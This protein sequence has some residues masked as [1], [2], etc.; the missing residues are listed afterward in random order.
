MLFACLYL[1]VN[2]LCLAVL[3]HRRYHTIWPLFL[4]FQTLTCVQ[5]GIRLYMIAHGLDTRE[6]WIRY[7]V[8]PET[9]L[10]LASVG[11]TLESLWKSLREIPIWRPVIM[12]GLCCW[13]TF[14]TSLFLTLWPAGDWYDKFQVYRADVFLNLA[15]LTFIGFWAGLHYTQ[16]WPRVARMHAGLL[17]A[18]FIG[19][20]V[21]V[22]WSAWARSN[23]NYRAWEMLCC[24]GWML[25]CHFLRREVLAIERKSADAASPLFAYRRQSLAGFLHAPAPM[26]RA[27]LTRFGH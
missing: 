19:H 21:M 26:P 24:F 16:R 8:A 10:L 11:V 14:G 5:A 23:L 12:S 22:D 15:I 3:I 17:A 1:L 13:I 9:G 7:W 4:A 25:N 20:V 2:L 18:L 27:D 6:D